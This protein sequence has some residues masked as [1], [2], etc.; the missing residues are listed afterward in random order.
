MSYRYIQNPVENRRI[1]IMSDGDKYSLDIF[2]KLSG[3]THQIHVP[4]KELET[5]CKGKFG[6]D[7]KLPEPKT[8]SLDEIVWHDYGRPQST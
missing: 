1:L 4:F 8:I 2:F 5:K 6:E 3:E 7:F